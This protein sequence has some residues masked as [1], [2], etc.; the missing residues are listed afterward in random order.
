MIG[1][2]VSSDNGLRLRSTWGVTPPCGVPDGEMLLKNVELRGVVSLLVLLEYACGKLNVAHCEST[3][4][5]PFPLSVGEAGRLAGK[6]ASPMSGGSSAWPFVRG[7]ASSMTDRT[8]RSFDSDLRG[9]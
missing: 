5:L 2:A 3:S 6:S 8:L 9:G 1:I 7:W 4:A